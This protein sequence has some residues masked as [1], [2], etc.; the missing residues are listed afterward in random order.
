MCLGIP[1]EVTEIRA[2]GELLMGTVDFGGARREVCLAYVADEVAQGD[3]VIVHVGFAISLVDKE[4]AERTFQL[5]EEL[6]AG[7]EVEGDER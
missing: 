1:G 7:L 5:L 6:G 4:E 3:W 2:D